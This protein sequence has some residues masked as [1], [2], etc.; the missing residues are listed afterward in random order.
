VGRKASIHQVT[1]A[2]ALAV[3]RQDVRTEVEGRS[4][5][6]EHHLKAKPDRVGAGDRDSRAIAGDIIAGMRISQMI[7]PA[8]ASPTGCR[9]TKG[10]PLLILDERRTVIGEDIR[11]RLQELRKSACDRH[12]RQGDI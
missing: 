5:D 10:V 8:S 9:N 7:G 2:A 11:N 1:H 4:D 3:V 12:H 6:E